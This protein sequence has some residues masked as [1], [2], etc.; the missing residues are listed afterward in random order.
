[1]RI[2]AFARVICFRSLFKIKGVSGVF[3]GS[4][5]ITVTKVSVISLFKEL[6]LA[7]V[8]WSICKAFY[9]FC[10]DYSKRI[11]EKID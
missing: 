3:F 8:I 11:P 7:V 5:F 1:M 4:E 10:R 9:N 2:T 6:F